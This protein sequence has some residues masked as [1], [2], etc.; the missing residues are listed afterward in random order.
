MN[1]KEMDPALTLALLAKF[2]E[3]EGGHQELL[4]QESEELDQFYENQTCPKCG[5]NAFEREYLKNHA[6]ADRKRGVAR[7]TLHCKNCRA[8]W[9]PHS[10][11]RL[12]DG[13]LA[14][15]QNP[16]HIFGRDNPE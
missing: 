15:L 11:I 5:G 9:D 8:H 16:L 1:F 6:F 4:Q 10:G 2:E 14:L 7:A 13:N 3:E 12:K